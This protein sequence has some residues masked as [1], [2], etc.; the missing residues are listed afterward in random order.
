[1]QKLESIKLFTDLQNVSVKYKTLELRNNTSEVEANK[2]MQELI[3]TYKSQLQQIKERSNF[4]S[5][6]IREQAQDHNSKDIYTTIVQLNSLSK[7]KCNYLKNSDMEFEH[8]CVKAVLLS[9]VDELSLVSDSIRNKEF[10][11]DKHA[12]FYI[13]EKVIINCFMN[14]LALK[15]MG[16]QISKVE[17]LSQ[18]VLSQIQTLS[19]ISI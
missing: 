4:I 12:Y 1:M 7:D 3:L 6:Q 14:F 18:A 10:L 17:A 8:T 5:K 11:K 16:I 2:K 13:Y 9:T 15:D 19:L